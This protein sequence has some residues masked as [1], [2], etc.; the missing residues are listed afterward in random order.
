VIIS[1][2]GLRCA[3]TKSGCEG[4][5]DA[6]L[7][8]IAGDIAHLGLDDLERLAFALPNLDREQLKEMPVVVGRRGARPFGPVEKAMRD[9]EPDRARARRRPR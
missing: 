9:I 8:Q 7:E 6:A 2:D 4:C 5:R 1:H 3:G